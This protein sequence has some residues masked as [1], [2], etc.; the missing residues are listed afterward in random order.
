MEEQHKQKRIKQEA[1]PG[2]QCVPFS[3]R[4]IVL[5]MGPDCGRHALIDVNYIHNYY[6][7]DYE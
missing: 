2:L 5:K 7:N 3:V 6:S 4:E 1:G